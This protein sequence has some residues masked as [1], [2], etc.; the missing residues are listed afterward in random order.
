VLP[1]PGGPTCCNLPPA[2]ETLPAWELIR[3]S[4]HLIEYIQ[5]RFMAAMAKSSVSGSDGIVRLNIGGQV[6]ATTRATLE[7]GGGGGQPTYFSALMSDAHRHALDRGTNAMFV[8]RDPTHFRHVLNY[9][10]DGV[11]PL[12]RLDDAQQLTEI[13]REAQFYAIEGLATKLR[14]HLEKLDAA[15]TKENSGE[16]E[17]KIEYAPL[18]RVDDLIGEFASKGYDVLCCSGIAEVVLQKTLKDPTAES[19][20]T[21]CFVKYLSRSQSELLDRLSR[22]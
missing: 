6:F 13:L 20:V 3:E 17:Y 2:T 8:D 15:A 7:N 10:R 12:E 16:K 22:N 4:S 21:I 11:V 18:N 14:Q 5:Q 1:L 19:I 9:L